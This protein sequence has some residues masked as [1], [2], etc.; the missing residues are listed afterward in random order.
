MSRVIKTVKITDLRTKISRHDLILHVDFRTISPKYKFS[1]IKVDI[2]FDGKCIK[3]FY[4]V[5]IHHSAHK[6]VLP[7]KSIISLTHVNYGRHVVRVDLTGLGSLAGLQD[8]K[9]V[10]FDYHPGVK[11]PI[12]KEIPKVKKIEVPNVII[13]TEDMKKFY[14]QM[15]ERRKKNYLLAE[16]RRNCVHAKKIHIVLVSDIRAYPLSLYD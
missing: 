3:S 9:K 5:V 7:I 15:R 13:I 10:A 14:Q 12:V 8:S 4:P 6:N 1:R 11:T 16:K 2:Y